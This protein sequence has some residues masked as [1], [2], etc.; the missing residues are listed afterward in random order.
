MFPVHL[1]HNASLLILNHA[2]KTETELAVSSLASSD[3]HN[4]GYGDNFCLIRRINILNPKRFQCP[5]SEYC[6]DNTGRKFYSMSV[7]FMHKLT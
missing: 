4:S 5:K 7:G 6:H 3:V 1:K 2:L